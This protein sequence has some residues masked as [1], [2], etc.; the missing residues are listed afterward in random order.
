MLAL[1]LLTAHSQKKEKEKERNEGANKIIRVLL[2]CMRAT[3]GM[4]I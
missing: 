1:L 3:T 2:F 4:A